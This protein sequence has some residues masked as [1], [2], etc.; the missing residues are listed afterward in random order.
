[1]KITIPKPCHENW[2]AMTPEEKGRFCSVCSKTVRD[3]TIASDDEIINAFSHPT[4]NICGN[5]YESQ[6]N[7]NLQYSYINSMFAKFAVGFILTTGGFIAI[8]A[9]QKITNDTVKSEEIQEIVLQSS[10]NKRA[11]QT[12][13]VGAPTIVSEDVLNTAQKSTTK[14]IP[15]KIPG[16]TVN[17]IPKDSLGKREL[18]IG[19]VHASLRDDQKPLVVINKKIISLEEFREID[20]QAIKT[21]EVLKGTAA[22]AIYGEKGKNGVILITTKKKWKSKKQETSGN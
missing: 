1:M 9:Q 20:T 4:E 18:R 7:R 10:L 22:A 15:A 11:M 14:E 2:E 16:L 3:F 8:H 13:L 6:L 19:G 12:M 5:F 21:M 17:Q